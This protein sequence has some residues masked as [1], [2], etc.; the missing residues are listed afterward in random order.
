MRWRAHP[1]FAS[2][3][4]HLK[5]FSKIGNHRVWRVEDIGQQLSKLLETEKITPEQASRVFT[6]VINTANDPSKPLPKGTIELRRKYP[7]LQPHQPENV[8]RV[9]R[10]VFSR[11]PA[12]RE[13]AFRR[14]RI[15][16][17]A[18]KYISKHFGQVLNPVQRRE[19]KDIFMGW[20]RLRFSNTGRIPDAAT[21]E[22]FLGH[23]ADFLQRQR[24]VGN[25]ADFQASV[26]FA[27]TMF[28]RALT[29]RARRPPSR[30]PPVR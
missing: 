18:G 30:K 29:S 25:R 16:A 14:Y 22:E 21:S 17:N 27:V 26:N 13:R 3:L 23:F 24:K 7:F 10:G 11:I 5:P 19:L 1:V 20:F 28:E 9:E 4:P 6:Y 2:R 8:V 12:R 15:Y